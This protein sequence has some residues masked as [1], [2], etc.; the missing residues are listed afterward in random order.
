ML[1]PVGPW[2]GAWGGSHPGLQVAAFS[3]S[4]C[5]EGLPSRPPTSWGHPATSSDLITCSVPGPGSVWQGTRASA[6]V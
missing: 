4:S 1:A 5:G 2:F 6:H 3:V